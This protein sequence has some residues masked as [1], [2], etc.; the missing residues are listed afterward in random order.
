MKRIFALL[1]FQVITFE[2]SLAAADMVRLEFDFAKSA[3][4]FTA[5]FAD[6]P[7]GAEAFYQ[8]TS[9]WLDRPGNLGSAPALFISGNNHSDDLFMFHKKKIQ[10]LP[11]STSVLLTMELELASKYPENSLGVGGSPGEGVTVKVGAVPFEPLAVLDLPSGDFHM[12]LDKGHQ[13]T[14]GT[15]MTS[16]GNIAKPEDGTENYVLLTRHQHGRPFT[17]TT[18]GDGSLWLIFGTDSGFEANT[19]LYYSRLTVWINRAD[20]PHL[21]VEPKGV[22][23]AVRLIW[24]QGT[25]FS[26]STLTSSWQMVPAPE[27]PYI[28][29]LQFDQRR[30]WKVVQP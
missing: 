15:H 23:G 21:W 18:A 9:S 19:A 26:S 8:L 2:A 4:G 3:H 20:T 10:G 29:S 28:D 30:F 25:L 27:R 22:T 16:V 13:T 12:N 7:Q 6:Y 1:L 24:N 17:A 14:D 11:P 5:G